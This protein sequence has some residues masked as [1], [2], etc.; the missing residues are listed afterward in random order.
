MR[1]K[2]LSLAITAAL[3]LGISSTSQAGTL[4]IHYVTTTRDADNICTASTRVGVPSNLGNVATYA[5][6]FFRQSGVKI[7]DG[8]QCGAGD[9]DFSGGGNLDQGSIMASAAYQYDIEPNGNPAVQEPSYD[10][11]YF[12]AVYTF[13]S[14]VNEAFLARFQLD[15]GAFVKPISLDS[16]T[17]ALDVIL[18]KDPQDEGV[19]TA[20]AWVKITDSGGST[21]APGEATFIVQPS[22]PLIPGDKLVM[23]FQLTDLEVL[24]TPGEEI[25]MTVTIKDTGDQYVSDQSATG[26]NVETVVV[27]ERGTEIELNAL[28][29]KAYVDVINGSVAFTGKDTNENTMAVL[30]T[31]KIA[32]QAGLMDDNHN[33][34]VFATDDPQPNSGTLTI[35]DGNFAAS[36]VDPGVVF[37]D[38][39]GDRTYSDE[40]VAD[41]A[42]GYSG[43]IKA[44]TITDGE[45]A[46]WQLDSTEILALANAG[47]S[48][49]III[50]DGTTEI[51]D[52]K[53]SPKV[54]LKIDYGAGN[55]DSY[56]GRFRQIKRNGTVCTLYNIPNP[57]AVDLLSVRIINK[58]DV[59]GKVIGTLRDESGIN[60]FTNQ[61]LLETVPSRA[62]VRLGQDS[63]QT[64]EAFLDS[65]PKDQNWLDAGNPESGWSGRATL[66]INSSITDMEVFGLVRNRKGGPLTNM[67]YGA[68][69][70]CDDER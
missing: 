46:E 27:S 41:P 30:G 51:N 18:I 24:A 19:A 9:D 34:W 7:P 32:N 22:E 66:T 42:G 43:D 28:T 57:T 6:E 67:S 14:A 25:N 53:E 20:Q 59:Q 52:F 69:Y 35:T 11:N 4:D 37:I 38:L 31:I 50:A 2:A 1:N 60:I 49:V 16:T 39:D 8:A 21:S 33:D 29:G 54:V 23:R 26:E 36:M 13:E 47:T 45:M 5:S 17:N 63:Q 44:D 12:Y 68:N 3:S 15:K 70:N 62:T 61:T 65:I 64:S 55:M 10:D 48:E 40:V 56:N 58:T